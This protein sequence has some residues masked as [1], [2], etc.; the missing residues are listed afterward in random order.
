ME[1]REQRADLIVGDAMATLN[2]GFSE[3]SVTTPGF[4][5]LHVA[6]HW[7]GWPLLAST[8][9]SGLKLRSRFRL[10]LPFSSQLALGKLLELLWV[11]FF[12]CKLG[13]IRAWNCHNDFRRVI[14][15]VPGTE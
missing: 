3:V 7:K 12:V 13:I 4:F 1:N 14:F 11:S 10:R 5:A 2:E 15:T 8:S 6:L 9:L